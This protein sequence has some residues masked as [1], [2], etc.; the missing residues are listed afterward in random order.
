MYLCFRAPDGAEF[1]GDDALPEV[2][3]RLREAGAAYWSTGSGDAALWADNPYN[4]VQLQFYFDGEGRFQ[5]RHVEPGEMPLLSRDPS[6]NGV[7]V[8]ILVG[9][10]PL[11]LAAGTLVSRDAAISAARHFV[12]HRAPDP[13]LDW[14]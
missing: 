1:L 7:P 13:A 11:E 5:L 14:A 2:E 10:D 6:A 12:D 3:A 4:P 9:G 8:R